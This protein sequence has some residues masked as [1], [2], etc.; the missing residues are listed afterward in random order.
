MLKRIGLILVMAVMLGLYGC[1]SKTP[2][3]PTI[4][5]ESLLETQTQE[6]FATSNT[7]EVKAEE[8]KT[9]EA[10]TKATASI[11]EK[12]DKSD[13]ETR[14]REIID[15]LSFWEYEYLYMYADNE[16]DGTVDFTTNAAERVRAAVL[17]SYP[18]DGVSPEE[19]VV[20]LDNDIVQKNAGDL[21]GMEVDMSLLPL[22]DDINVAQCDD[23]GTIRPVRYFNDYED[24]GIFYIFGDAIFEDDDG[25][26]LEQQLYCGY[27]GFFDEYSYN[28]EVTFHFERNDNSAYGYTLTEMTFSR[29]ED[30]G[31]AGVIN[32]AEEPFYGI[33]CCAVKE[34]DEAV[35]VA[36]DLDEKGF[37]GSVI[38]SSAW[39]DL[40]QDKWYVVTAGIYD[41]EL[42]AQ[43]DLPN[44]QN[45]GYKDAYIKYTGDRK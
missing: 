22:A 24:E 23:K 17:A 7:E 35:K 6:S 32:R 16:M 3:A 5:P 28:Y 1:G 19:T 29:F 33:W 8:S 38:I 12:E 27:W 44:V 15:A 42:Q 20:V 39:T 31:A 26:S 45:A 4:Q 2:D 30:Y 21:F 18:E 37:D 9:E 13:A 10:N 43:N 40:N 11:T 25:Y 36:Q 14:C 34:E 41:S